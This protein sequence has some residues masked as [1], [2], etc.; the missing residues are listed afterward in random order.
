M[1]HHTQEE[2]GRLMRKR[3]ATNLFF[4]FCCSSSYRFFSLLREFPRNLYI[5]CKFFIPNQTIGLFFSSQTIFIALCL[6]TF[7]GE[8]FLIRLVSF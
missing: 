3:R 4:S 2:G 1:D 7:I 6:A 8:Y 5:Y